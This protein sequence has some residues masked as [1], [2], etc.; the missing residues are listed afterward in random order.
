MGF[1]LVLMKLADAARRKTL[2]V[3][4]ERKDGN[5]ISLKDCTEISRTISALLEV[6]DPITDAYDLEV[7]SPGLDRPLTKL[8]DFKQ[9]NGFEVK[10]ETLFPLDGRK[11]FRGVLNGI[12]EENIQIT[13]DKN[14]IE[15]GFSDIRN[16][17]LIAT[18][19][20]VEEKLRQQKKRAK[21]SS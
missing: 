3:M 4:V 17:K 20:L 16:A 2:T 19:A 7:C 13:V 12:K 8:E 1:R 18:D 6:E 11:R 10:I 9:Y 14:K 21:E 15:I 5:N